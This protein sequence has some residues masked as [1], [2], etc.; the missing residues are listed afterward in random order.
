[1]PKKEKR[2][3]K[4]LGHLIGFQTKH[5]QAYKMLEIAQNDVSLFSAV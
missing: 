4:N 2:R 1:M 5:T 3:K